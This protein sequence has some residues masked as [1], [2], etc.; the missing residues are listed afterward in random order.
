MQTI[1]ISVLVISFLF[2]GF[3]LFREMYVVRKI[4]RLALTKYKVFEPLLVRLSAN[5]D[6]SSQE[7]LRLSEDPSL[8]YGIFHMLEAY[9]RMDRF[10]C[11][12]YNREKGAESFL[13][14][15]LEFPTELGVPPDEIVLLEQVEIN[16][17][18][19]LEYCVFRFRVRPPHWAAKRNWMIGVCGPYR[20]E[21]TPYEV[22]SK[23]FSRFNSLG[24]VAPSEEAWWV[25]LNIGK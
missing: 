13:V 8:R 24:N 14:N 6:I 16:D 15:W 2:G 10:P 1:L 3:F 11:E 25:H 4:R 22:P 9:N 7:V 19:L 21:S 20:P 12:Y 17:N 5:E 23:V 18:E